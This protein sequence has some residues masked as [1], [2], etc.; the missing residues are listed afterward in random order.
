MVG[1]R[2]CV[3]QRRM[4]ARRRCFGTLTT[5]FGRRAV[6]GM[7]TAALWLAVALSAGYPLVWLG[8]TAEL[9]P[10]WPLFA[11]VAL[12]AAVI[13]FGHAAPVGDGLSGEP[14]QR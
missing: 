5:L 14:P 2:H 8:G 11:L 13:V 6:R 10:V 4:R 9:L 3:R 7:Q 1:I 12:H